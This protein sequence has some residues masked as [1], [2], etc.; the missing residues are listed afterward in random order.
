MSYNLRW[1]DENRQIILVMF[2]DEVTYQMLYQLYEECA[3]MLDTVSH[4]V[5]LVHDLTQLRLVMKIDIAAMAKLP[6]M[7][8]IQHPNWWGSYFA[9]PKA[10]SKI[11]LDVASRLFPSMMRATY[12]ADTVE[13]ALVEAQAK[14]AALA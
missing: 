8:I 13:A 12:T 11:I 6:R 9:N 2:G 1:H 7:R 5:I 3:A 14:L 10:Q 4:S